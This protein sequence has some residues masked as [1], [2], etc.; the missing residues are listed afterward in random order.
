MDFSLLYRFFL[1]R[2]CQKIKRSTACSV[3]FSFALH[4]LLFKDKEKSTTHTLMVPHCEEG[5]RRIYYMPYVREQATLSFAR[6]EQNKKARRKKKTVV[7]KEQIIGPVHMRFVDRK[8]RKKKEQRPN[9]IHLF[10]EEKT[11]DI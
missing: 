3:S 2:L 10:L 5:T 11:R 4:W 9:F 6:T 7:Y 1:L 8:K